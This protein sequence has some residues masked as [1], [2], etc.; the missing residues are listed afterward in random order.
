MP[1]ET[2]GLV[3]V[4]LLGAAIAERLIGAGFEVLGY[5]VD[6]ARL[7]AL[8]AMGGVVAPCLAHVTTVKRVVLSLPTSAIVRDVI[9]EIGADFAPG[10][11]VVDT[12]TGDPEETAELGARLAGEGVLYV[13]A[14]VAGSSRQARAGDAVVMAGGSAEAFAAARGVIDAFARTSFHVGPCGAGARMKLVVNLVLG[15]NRAVLAEGLEFARSLGVDPPAALEVLKCGPAAS[16]V[17]ETKGERMLT[18]NFEPEARLAQHLK[19]VRLI[20]EAG[21]RKG[22]SLPLSELHAAL[23]ERLVEEGCGALDNSAIVRAFRAAPA[24]DG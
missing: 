22:A 20:L 13:D 11:L 3:G 18:G 2:I 6:P 21:R 23:L 12:T 10:T 1:V 9:E 24:G 15:L 16:R 4:G 7:E 19:D 5:D 8:R 17:M 14:T